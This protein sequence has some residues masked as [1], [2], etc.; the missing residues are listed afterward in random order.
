LALK[1]LISGETSK[2]QGL[3]IA[4]WKIDHLDP[5][6]V[7]ACYSLFD[8]NRRLN[9]ANGEVIVLPKDV[10]VVIEGAHYK[11]QTPATVARCG[12]VWFC[13]E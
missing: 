4:H 2:K 12:H 1:E 5:E 6:I 7:E 3:K 13:D 11:M 8:D 10:I 9:L